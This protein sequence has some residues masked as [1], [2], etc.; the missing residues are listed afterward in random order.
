[1]NEL[2]EIES[3]GLLPIVGEDLN[4]QLDNIERN[5][6]EIM[7]AEYLRGN[8]GDNLYCKSID[9]K[10]SEYVEDIKDAILEGTKNS[11]REDVVFYDNKIYIIYKIKGDKEE[12]I[13]SLPY[14]FIDERFANISDEIDY[15]SLEDLSCTIMYQDGGFVKLQNF[16]TLYYD[17]D[18]KEFCWRINGQSTGLFARGPQGSAGA[19]G[20]C[21]FVQIE[22]VDEND[23][24]QGYA[25]IT[26]VQVVQEVEEN[27]KTSIQTTWIPVSEANIQAGDAAISTYEDSEEKIRL[28]LSNIFE[29][30]GVWYVSLN[31]GNMLSDQ[32]DLGMLLN[33]LKLIS[34]IDVKN[35]E[36]SDV[37]NGLVIPATNDGNSYHTLTSVVNEGNKEQLWIGPSSSPTSPYTKDEIKKCEIDDYSSMSN[38]ELHMMYPNTYA[39]KLHAD[40]IE[41]PRIECFKD[42]LTIVS[43]K[44]V[45]IK[46]NEDEGI[47]LLP[48]GIAGNKV[49]GSGGGYTQRRNVEI[50]GDIDVKSAE[51]DDKYVGWDGNVN[52][53]GYVKA[54]E[55]I[56]DG[57]IYNQ[58]KV[59][60]L[61]TTGSTTISPIRNCDKFDALSNSRY[62]TY[63]YN[64]LTC[65][66]NNPYDLDVTF[67]VPRLSKYSR[68][69]IIHNDST[70]PI[71]LRITHDHNGL[72]HDQLV[73][74]S[75]TNENY[76]I[77]S[78]KGTLKLT[79]MVDPDSQASGKNLIGKTYWFAEMM[80]WERLNFTHISVMS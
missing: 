6:I 26:Q 21:L 68:E 67:E 60:A 24:H 16:P 61:K 48:Y 3:Y 29:D 35:E 40:S 13:S 57:V 23:P 18:V 74:V 22:N 56:N 19:N 10:D 14:T 73:D 37:M 71:H 34:P 25:K 77:I 46:R 59:H 31:G 79:I 66:N 45:G 53:D 52:I 9:I 28:I 75:S 72:D 38:S 44:G 63:K 7:S 12:I 47:E 30:S 33:T 64:I 58:C 15:S 49:S 55:F 1:M 80:G 69:Y 70:H 27:G 41:T 62:N 5:F 78:P 51:L 8:D 36:E 2:H 17:S 65:T 54:S 39:K 42:Q 76:I 4:T 50:H 20:K 32:I 11:T 43:W